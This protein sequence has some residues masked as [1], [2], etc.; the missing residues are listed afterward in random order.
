[1]AQS[2]TNIDP[3]TPTGPSAM[4][5]GAP[6]IRA[7]KQAVINILGATHD[8]TAEP[9]VPTGHALNGHSW[10]DIMFHWNLL[11]SS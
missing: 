7:L 2:N 5:V 9:A 10:K 4:S 3:T 1:M 8:V 11:R 6:D